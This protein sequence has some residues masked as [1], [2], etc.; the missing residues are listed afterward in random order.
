MTGNGRQIYLISDDRLMEHDTGGG[1]HP[2]TPERLAAI[3]ERIGERRGARG[4]R[5]ISPRKAEWRW[6]IA[7][8]DEA[9]L[10]RM[11]EAALSGRTSI[12]H[13]DNRISYGSYEAAF[14]AAG[15]GLAGIDILESGGKG[16]PFG[17]VRPPG[18]HA[19]KDR[20]MGFCLLNNAVIA[21][22]YWQQRYGRGRILIFD[23]DAHHGNGV[24]NAFHREGDVFYVSVH[25][26]PTFS[27]PGTGF[28]E[29]RGA[30]PG[31]GATLNIPLPPGARDEAV[32]SAIE[33][34]VD[35]MVSRFRPDAIIACAGF[36][37]HERDDMS[38]LSFTAGLYRLLGRTLFRWSREHCSGRILSLL[39]GGY[40]YGAL[41]DSIEC[42][43]E[44]LAGVME[45][46]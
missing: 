27:Y 39:E 32:L 20:A 11:E 31:E 5:M 40:H 34:R 33:E 44:G 2:E 30:G 38:G 15:A 17:A 4:L 29:D 3:L 43:L 21:A 24:Q 16:V 46:R 22:R 42:Y 37:G 12:D 14:L 10:F 28:A 23:F 18:H 19:E 45:G 7:A 41:A 8:H 13:P 6:V 36:D 1:E 26:H 35:T 9:Y 25:E